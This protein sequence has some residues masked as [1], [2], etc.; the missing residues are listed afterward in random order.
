MAKK[1]KSTKTNP[2][3]AGLSKLLKK[4]A[5]KQGTVSLDDGTYQGVISAIELGQTQKGK[6]QIDWTLK[7]LAGEFE[8]RTQHKYD[9]L[10]SQ[11]NVNWLL[12][13]LEALECEIPETD[14]DLKDALKSCIGKK[15]EFSTRTSGDF[16][17]V[18][19]NELLDDEEIDD[20]DDDD[21]DNDDEEGVD[22]TE[23][24]NSDTEEDEDDG[25]AFKKKDRV[26]VDFDGEEYAGKITKIDTE[27]EEATVKF[28]DGSTEVVDLDDMTAEE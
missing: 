11:E 5:P 15:I 6:A 23:D 12:G 4:G 27:K 17:N 18:Y 3:L 26:T 7:V 25:L 28:D 20:S 21:D 10:A 9:L 1:K 8:G 2:A 14:K 13:T 16:T 24:E 19:I 22:E